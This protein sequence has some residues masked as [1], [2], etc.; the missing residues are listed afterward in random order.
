MSVRVSLI[1]INPSV[2][3]APALT[4]WAFT[5]I[6]RMARMKN[7]GDTFDEDDQNGL[8]FLNSSQSDGGVLIQ[9]EYSSIGEGNIRPASVTYPNAI[10]GTENIVET[11]RLP[12][13]DIH[14]A[15]LHSALNGHDG[16][17]NWM[18]FRSRCDRRGKP[19][20]REAEAQ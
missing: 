2:S 1:R 13:L 4:N 3:P 20:S 14:T 16:R 18:A 15:H 7:I 5:S 12:L 17:H 10:P 6:A 19:D 8:F 9:P 11:H